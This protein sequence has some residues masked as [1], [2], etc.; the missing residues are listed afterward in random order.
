M[1]TSRAA[2][3]EGGLGAHAEQASSR[4]ARGGG[5]PLDLGSQ[6][7]ARTRPLSPEQLSG[8]MRLL[9]L[10]WVGSGEASLDGWPWGP[11]NCHSHCIE[12]LA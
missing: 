10:P 5:K 7:Q 8:P 9:C 6:G 2:Q 1:P 3:W 4:A 11:L 12:R